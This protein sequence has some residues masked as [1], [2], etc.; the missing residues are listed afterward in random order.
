MHG[1][2]VR[3]LI[4]AGHRELPD[5]AYSWQ[6][7][8]DGTR[9]PLMS[10]PSA[11]ELRACF[12]D[13]AAWVAFRGG[14]D[15]TQGLAD[16]PDAVV[17]Q[18]VDAVQAAMRDLIHSGQVQA[19]ATL[20]LEDVPSSFLQEAPL[21]DGIWLDRAVLALAEWAAELKKHGYT[22]TE[23]LD[24]HPLALFEI[25]PADGTPDNS[26]ALLAEA[27]ERLAGYPG[28]SQ[29][30]DGRPFLHVGDYKRWRGRR[31]KDLPKPDP[32]VLISSWNAWVEA[33][34]GEGVATLAGIPIGTLSCWA[35]DSSIAVLPPDE[36][37]QRQ[38]ERHELLHLVSSPSGKEPE[39]GRE[40]LTL[41]AERWCRLLV[42]HLQALYATDDAI[43]TISR[44]Y[45][46]GAEVL[47]PDTRDTLTGGIAN[48][49][50]LVQSFNRLVAPDLDAQ[51]GVE[52][53]Q[54]PP[55]TRIDLACLR[56]TSQ[57]QRELAQRFLVDHARA[58]TLDDL[59]QRHDA[60]AIFHKYLNGDVLNET[61]R[62]R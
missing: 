45:F 32:G 37:R 31:L 2:V 52:G 43:A 61:L 50:D 13:D 9:W 35:E 6:M 60:S 55:T 10:R 5:N 57:A 11:E 51:A 42:M 27:N 53:A 62:G 12:A 14:T 7:D 54:Q 39:A 48:A 38:A 18:R 15:Y 36:A 34:G 41:Q 33:H 8:Q 1:W 23:S 59:G 28:R 44:H 3:A 47:F 4:D 56:S 46:G 25:S 22:L 58:T 16:V 30:I 17:K 40:R 29:D 21:V 49:E 19:G 24:E 26:A 20:Q